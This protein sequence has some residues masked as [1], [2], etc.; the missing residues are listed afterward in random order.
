M[1]IKPKSEQR[2]INVNGHNV[3]IG[4]TGN[5]GYISICDRNLYPDKDSRADRMNMGFNIMMVPMM[6]R[7]QLKDLSIAINEVLKHSK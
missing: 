7:E 4:L 1:N 6:S 5:V 2:V 3:S